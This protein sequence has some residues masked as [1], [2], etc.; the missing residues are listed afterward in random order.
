MAKLVF[1][2]KGAIS[3]SENSSP[4][5]FSPRY[6]LPRIHNYSNAQGPQEKLSTRTA[7]A[8]TAVKKWTD[9]V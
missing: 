8:S 3:C 2:T 7:P 6:R 9:H 5:H 4:L 1:D